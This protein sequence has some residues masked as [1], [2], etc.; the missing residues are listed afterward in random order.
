MTIDERATGIQSQIAIETITRTN[1]ALPL[2]DCANP[3]RPARRS[4]NLMLSTQRE[5]ED[6]HHRD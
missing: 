6:A 3:A 5:A 1:E 2:V 4:G